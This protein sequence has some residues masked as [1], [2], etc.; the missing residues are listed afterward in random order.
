MK[1]GQN[2]TNLPLTSEGL[3]LLDSAIHGSLALIIL[4]LVSGIDETF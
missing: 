2:S 3:D 4:F 1:R